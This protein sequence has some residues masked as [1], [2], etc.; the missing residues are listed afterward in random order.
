MYD[1]TNSNNTKTQPDDIHGT[2]HTRLYQ[3]MNV[4]EDICNNV[5]SINTNGK[6]NK[7]KESHSENNLNYRIKSRVND[8]KKNKQC[9]D[10]IVTKN[11]TNSHNNNENK[12]SDNASNNDNK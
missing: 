1:A 5:A 7:D 10:G 12:D 9:I 3:S 2:H 6:N 8:A 11:I 4:N